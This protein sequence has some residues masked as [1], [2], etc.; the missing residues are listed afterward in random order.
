MTQT[1][2]WLAKYSEHCKGHIQVAVSALQ[3]KQNWVDI[4]NNLMHE[5]FG[6]LET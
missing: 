4:T 1:K 3:K 2:S 5:A 6:L